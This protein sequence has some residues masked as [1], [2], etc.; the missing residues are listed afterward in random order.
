MS[1]EIGSC[2]L[3][4]L[5][6]GDLPVVTGSVIIAANQTLKRG[7]VLGIITTGGQGKLVDST[8]TD[9]SQ[10]AKLVLLEDVT[11]GAAETK[12]APVAKTGQFNSLAL[13]VGG[14]D[15]VADH[16]DNLGRLAGNSGIFVSTNQA[17]VNG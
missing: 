14:T 8:S 13:I 3:D 11:T 5:L 12:P 2:K 10:S 7:A 16:L 9:G 15:D 17:A 6:A 4:N 1:N